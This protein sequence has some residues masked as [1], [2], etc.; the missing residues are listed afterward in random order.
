MTSATITADPET[1]DTTLSWI[2]PDERGRELEIVAV[3]K[4]DCLLVIHVMPTLY[5]K[6]GQ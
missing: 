2:G 5:R 3:E 1:G 6:G 4:A